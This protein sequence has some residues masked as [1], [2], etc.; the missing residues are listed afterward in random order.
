[1][2]ERTNELL[3]Q[4]VVLQSRQVVAQEKALENQ[5]VLIERQRRALRRRFPHLIGLILLL[6][7]PYRFPWIRYFS[8]R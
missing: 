8:R 2:S 6:Y 7:G 3:A 1:M 4:L 5:Q